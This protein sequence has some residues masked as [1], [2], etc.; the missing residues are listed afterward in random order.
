MKKKFLATLGLLIIVSMVLT[1]CWRRWRRHRPS[2][3]IRWFVGLGTGTDPAQVA[4]QEEVVKDF[5]ASQY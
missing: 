4:V 2:D 3:K 1:A 5:N